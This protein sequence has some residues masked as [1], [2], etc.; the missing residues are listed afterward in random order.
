MQIFPYK[1]KEIS[2]VKG[3]VNN[4]QNFVRVVQERPCETPYLEYWFS[5]QL[6]VPKLV[7][8]PS[9]AKRIHWDHD[10]TET[11]NTHL[12]MKWIGSYYVGFPLL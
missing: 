5:N 1:S 8:S 7:E 11:N 4:V 3:V 10:S 6:E 9:M 12:I 2:N